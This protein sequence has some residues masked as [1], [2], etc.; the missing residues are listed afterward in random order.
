[1]SFVGQLDLKQTGSHNSPIAFDGNK[2][3]QK[4][5]N[6]IESGQIWL[7]AMHEIQNLWSREQ[8]PLQ[9]HKHKHK[10]KNFSRRNDD[11]P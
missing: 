9:N 10:H 4:I 1:M 6:Q 5:S 11:Q 2:K 3:H 8:H 7:M